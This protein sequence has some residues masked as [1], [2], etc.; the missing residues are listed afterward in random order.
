MRAKLLIKVVTFS[1]MFAALPSWAQD[2]EYHSR[3]EHVIDTDRDSI[4]LR[5]GDPSLK[6]WVLPEKPSAPKDNLLT[7][8]RVDLGKKLFFDP[9]LS[10]EGNLACVSCHNPSF[11]WAEPISK[12]IGFQGKAMTRNAQ[13]LSNIAYNT[14]LLWDGR[15]ETLDEQAI[16]PVGAADIMNADFDKLLGFL[17]TDKDY[18]KSFELAYPGEAITKPII[19]KALASFERTLIIRDTPFDRWIGG[20]ASAMSEQAIRGFRVF[21]DPQKGNC[22]SCHAAPNFVDNG[23]HNIGLPSF[24]DKE[25]DMGRFKQRKVA[26]L[27]GAFKTP[28]IRDIARTAP[29]FH[30]GSAKDLMAVVEHYVKG[31]IVKENI[32]KQLKPLTL[33]QQE[34]EDLVMFM[35]ALSAPYR[36]VQAPDLVSEAH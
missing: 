26:V 5:A 3:Y 36:P 19:S 15:K 28:A 2:H 14:T 35:K 1:I 30:D 7:P 29:Y 9:R 32:S 33:T 12:S 13:S 27:K 23:F 8:E 25:P 6:K 34:K 22:A 20:D 4:V 21:I 18:K 16:G 10:R 24:G 11:G 31:G 17:K